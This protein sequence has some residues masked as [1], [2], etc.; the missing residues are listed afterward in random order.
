MAITNAQQYKQL[1]NPPMKGKKRP[2]YRGEGGYQGGRSDTPAGA[3]PAGD[4]E[5]RSTAQQT[6]NTRAAIA[7]A[8]RSQRIADIEKF[9]NR[10]PV[11]FGEKFRTNLLSP[12]SV[13][14]TAFGKIVGIPGLGFLSNINV[15][16]F[17]GYKVIIKEHAY[18]MG[19]NFISRTNGVIYNLDKANAWILYKN[20]LNEK[21]I[22]NFHVRNIEFVDSKFDKFF[23]D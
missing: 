14:K 19:S 23:E 21:M 2:G 16:P 11:G 7:E 15:N 20:D 13:A 17:F 22:S 18:G 6:A 9:I 5:D 12:R 3:A 1:V 4:V 10:P 8:Q